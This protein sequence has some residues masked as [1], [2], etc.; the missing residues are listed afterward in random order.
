MLIPHNEQRRSWRRRR[1]KVGRRV[2]A[3]QVHG[4][5][6]SSFARNYRTYCF[7]HYV[8]FCTFLSPIH[9]F[10]YGMI[11]TL[12]QSHHHMAASDRRADDNDKVAWHARKSI[13]DFHQLQSDHSLIQALQRARAAKTTKSFHGNTAGA[14][15]RRAREATIRRADIPYGINA[16]CNATLKIYGRFPRLLE[17]QSLEPVLKRMMI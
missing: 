10:T 4:N 2:K 12:P 13:E 11:L 6:S 17:D 9:C 8:F 7:V 16:K 1:K 3:V 15:R 14:S 5:N